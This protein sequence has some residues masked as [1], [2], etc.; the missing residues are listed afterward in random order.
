MF[1]EFIQALFGC[2]HTH[3]SFPITIRGRREAGSATY[4]V[5]LDCGREFSYDWEAMKMAP[6]R[7]NGAARGAANSE[8]KI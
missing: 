6:A 1:A 3:S 8:V 7:G 4:I 5:C 2:S